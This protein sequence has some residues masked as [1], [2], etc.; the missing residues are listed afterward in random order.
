MV[1]NSGVDIFWVR[2]RSRQCRDGSDEIFT[3]REHAEHRATVREFGFEEVVNS[4]GSIHPV[5][6]AFEHGE[7]LTEH[8]LH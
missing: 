3:V 8:A 4:I 1:F 7:E 2:F 5:I 6:H